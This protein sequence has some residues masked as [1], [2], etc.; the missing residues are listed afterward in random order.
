MYL[1]YVDES[2]DV[3]LN[4]SP[5]K[6]FVLSAIVVHELRWKETLKNLIEFR[7]LLRD[8]KG[9]KLRDEIHCSEL[10][11][12]PGDLIRIKRNDR[13]DII[14]KCMDW[15]NIQPE[16]NIFSVAVNK[17][18]RTDDIFELAWNTLTMR[19]ENTIRYGN[20]SGPRNPDD[21][22]I[23]LSDNTE[24]EKLRKLIR[25]MR[26]FNVIP[27]RKEI[28]NEGN[29]NLK[30]EYVIEDPI[31]RDSQHSF[32]HQ[33]N[34]V[35]AYCVRQRYEPNSYMQKKGGHN[36]YKRLDNV[37]VKKVSGKNEYGI[38]EL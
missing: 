4:N 27:N 29:R 5:T 12:K 16:L 20:F 38:V 10:I 9:L 26:H 31:F 21:R 37:V 15:L 30:L 7:R 22:G 36:Y 14:K 1:M 19:F 6:Y 25:K 2:G 35:L 23:I 33:M 24:G 3:G 28:Y 32:L 11:N 34:D 8:T 17:Q 13:L 18:N